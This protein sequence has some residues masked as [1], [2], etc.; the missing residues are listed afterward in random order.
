MTLIRS[1][2]SA[3]SSWVSCKNV[4]A[5][6]RNA[7]KRKSRPFKRLVEITAACLEGES[8]DTTLKGGN[9][10]PTQMGSDIL[11]DRSGRCAIRL[12]RHRRRR[13]TDRASSVLGFPGHSCPVGCFGFNPFSSDHLIK[14]HAVTLDRGLGTGR[15]KRSHNSQPRI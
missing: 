3:I 7:L 9:Y 8:A 1:K 6:R 14:K 15:S 2:G 11:L 10:V 4:M 5:T 12:Y 13:G